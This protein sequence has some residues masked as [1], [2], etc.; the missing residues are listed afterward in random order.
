MDIVRLWGLDGLD[1]LI[2]TAMV[3][4]S[5][6]VPIGPVCKQIRAAPD[7]NVAPSSHYYQLL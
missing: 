6:V 3:I 1:H 2:S 5:G 4:G 7:D